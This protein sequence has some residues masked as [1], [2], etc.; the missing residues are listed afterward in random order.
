MARKRSRESWLQMLM[1]ILITTLFFLLLVQAS[2]SLY[3]TS[4][5]VPSGGGLPEGLIKSRNELSGTGV[6]NDISIEPTV[7]EIISVA[8]S[9]IGIA[10]VIAFVAAGLYLMLGFGS[11]EASGRARKIVLWSMAGLAIIVLSAVI[12]RAVI[13]LV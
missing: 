3:A 2:G 5:I 11:D 13:G 9:Y 6:R 4:L 12:V 10:A 8:M 7:N 1:G